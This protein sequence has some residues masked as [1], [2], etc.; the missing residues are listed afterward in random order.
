VGTHEAKV[1]IQKKGAVNQVTIYNFQNFEVDW[2]VL[3]VPESIPGQE[4]VCPPL[5]VPK[6]RAGKY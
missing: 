3:L 2:L 5:G 4:V 1:K 6:V